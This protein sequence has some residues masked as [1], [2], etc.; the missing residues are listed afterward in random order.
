MLDQLECWEKDWQM[1]F[2]IDKCHILT[3]SR[4]R[5]QIVTDYSLHGQGFGKVEK[6]MGWSWQKTLTGD[7]MSI[8]SQ[9]KWTGPACSLTRTWKGVP[10]QFKQSATRA[11]YAQSWSTPPLCGTPTRNTC[12]TNWRW[13]REELHGVFAVTSGI[14]P[15][16]LPWQKKKAANSL[17]EGPLYIKHDTMLYNF[18][19]G[20]FDAKPGEGTL[21]FTQNLTHGHETK[22]L[23]PHSKIVGV[24]MP[25]I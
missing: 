16:P 17:P 11:L 12:R 23:I 4:K 2:N 24:S 15:A 22:L 14:P 10:S 25:I 3:V 19:G 7:S 8:L 20:L 18:V 21:S 1:T 5:K 6:T 13:P 9:P